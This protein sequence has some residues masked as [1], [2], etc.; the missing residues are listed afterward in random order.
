MLFMFKKKK[1]LKPS[2]IDIKID[3]IPSTT[4]N[5]TTKKGLTSHR[6]TQRQYFRSL[7]SYVSVFE[8]EYAKTRA[9]S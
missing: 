4:A 2:T 8:S 9:L 6:K 3:K 1:I 7:S 5:L